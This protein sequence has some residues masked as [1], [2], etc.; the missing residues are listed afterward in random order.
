MYGNINAT[1]VAF[2]DYDQLYKTE[3]DNY[4]FRLTSLQLCT[5]AKG[6]LIG[7]RSVITNYTAPQLNATNITTMNQIGAVTA[8]GIS[9]NSLNIDA[10]NGEYLA[11]LTLAFGPQGPISYF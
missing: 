4:V 3:I 9:C 6:T 8:K 2:S 7:I 11:T 5:D 10:V 1:D